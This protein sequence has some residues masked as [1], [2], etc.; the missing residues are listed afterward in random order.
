MHFN[1]RPRFWLFIIAVMLI[2]FGVSFFSVQNI[3]REGRQEIHAAQQQRRAL[4]E[5]VNKLQE[6][7]TFIRSDDYIIRLARNELGMLMPDEIRY[8]DTLSR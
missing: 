1:V 2:A 5:K 4:Q 7:L 6:D 3:L 8:T